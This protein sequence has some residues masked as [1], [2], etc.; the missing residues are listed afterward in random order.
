MIISVLYFLYKNEKH[1][2]IWK[3]GKNYIEDTEMEVTCN[4][5]SLVYIDEIC[6]I[7][8]QCTVI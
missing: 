3:K 2:R 5:T 1:K 8:S 7:I 4:P 6:N